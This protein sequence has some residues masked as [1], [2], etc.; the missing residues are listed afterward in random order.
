MALQDAHINTGDHYPEAAAAWPDGDGGTRSATPATPGQAEAEG[1]T[2]PLGNNAKS[3]SAFQVDLYRLQDTAREILHW[4]KR[5]QGCRRWR[6]KGSNVVE[7][8]ATTADNRWHYKK[9]QQCADVWCCPLCAIAIQE[10]RRAEMAAAIAIHRARGGDVMLLTLTNSH[11]VD[12]S[13]ADLLDRQEK[14]LHRF[15]SARSS[16]SIWAD[17]D[18]IGHIKNLEGTHGANGWHPHYHVLLFVRSH[19]DK[20]DRECMQ[21][22]IAMRWLECCQAAGLPLP[23]LE[24]GARL[25]GYKGVGDYLAKTGQ[26]AVKRWALEDELAK[27][28]TK[29]GRKGQRTPFDLLRD[30][31]L[32]DKVAA[33]L[34]SEYARVFKGKRQLVWSRG[35]K[36]DLAV[37][38][39]SDADLLQKPDIESVF[40]GLL[41]A[42]QWACI[43][44]AGAR[45]HVI[46]AGEAGGWPLVVEL[47]E[48]AVI[49]FGDEVKR[50]NDE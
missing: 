29:R 15:W 42:H 21:R 37:Q 7:L 12:D 24:R 3:R 35:L 48:A 34:F 39:Q 36:A 28:H 22:V 13:L 4:K 5:L 2:A 40:K 6:Q 43:V 18:K 50:G 31:H 47:V 23:S 45:A 33:G 8:Y 26:D 44:K 11:D 16:R 41:S 30:A 49:A 25:D 20:H 9:L 17:L 27:S 19:L 10:R 1:A 32:G 46:A 38:E 14:A